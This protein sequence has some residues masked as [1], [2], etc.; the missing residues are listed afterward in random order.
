[1]S[2]GSGTGQAVTR[3]ETL[4]A[5]L[6]RRGVRGGIIPRHRAMAGLAIP[7]E[8]IVTAALVALGLAAGV[9]FALPPLA[10]L[11]ARG[12]ELVL[13]ALGVPGG[14]GMRYTTFFGVH[15]LP[16]PYLLAGAGEPSPLTW[17]VLAGVAAGFILLSLILPQRF[18]PLRYFLRFLAL[19]LAITLGYFALTPAGSFPYT[20]ASYSG[21]LLAAAQVVLVLVPLLLGFTWFVFDVSWGRKLLL[22]AL[23][24]GHLAVFIPL[25]VM[26]H[27]WLILQGSLALLPVLF[28]VFGLLMYVMIFV[29]FYGWGMSWPPARRQT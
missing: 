11:W 2:A 14:V 17:R 24:L 20:L 18:T 13:P 16:T 27:A 21:G 9:F 19:L 23:L 3:R 29:A 26:A 5:D 10:E 25:Q 7:R 22:A 28:L 12:F 4:L 6:R 15:A 1:L 8:R